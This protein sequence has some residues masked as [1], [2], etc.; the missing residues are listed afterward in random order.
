MGQL[1]ELKAADGFTSQAYVAQPQGTPRGAMVIV[2]EIFGLNH[3]IK[4][5]ADLYASEG[6]LSIAPAFFDRVERGIDLGYTPQDIETARAQMGKV[7]MDKVML[8]VAAAV[9]HVKGAG[10]VGMVGYC[11][12]GRVCWISAAKVDGVS[13]TVSYYGGGVPGLADLN[14]KCPTMF[15]W[16]ELDHAIPLDTVAAFVAKHPEAA[17]TSFVY[18]GAQHGFNCDERGS[19][20]EASA[21]LARSRT[22]EFLRKHVG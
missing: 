12:G 1:I 19:W 22:M 5:V 9:A 11:W 15:H 14:A 4:A 7:D 8:D 17:A 21:K 20:N 16:G 10:K 2:Q 18:E 6:Y 3:H 13:A